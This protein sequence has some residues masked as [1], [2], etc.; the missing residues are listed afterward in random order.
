MPAPHKPP[1]CYSS[2]LL[3][4][5]DTLTDLMVISISYFHALFKFYINRITKY[6]LFMSSFLCS[7][8]V[9]WN[10]FFLLVAK[11]VFSILQNTSIAILFHFIVDDIFVVCRL[12]PLR[13]L[14]LCTF[15]FW[16]ENERKMYVYVDPVYWDGIFL[17]HSFLKH[18]HQLVRPPQL[19]L[20]LFIIF[21]PYTN[22]FLFIIKN[23]CW[24]LS[25]AFPV[26]MDIII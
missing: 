19:Y 2:Q 20:V 16:F 23:E 11:T 22:N 3:L 4:F 21:M 1:T 7:T 12:G 18:L 14:L 5:S 6:V 25:N 26:S 17:S 13:I 10:I 8:L 9:L 15:Y 24:I